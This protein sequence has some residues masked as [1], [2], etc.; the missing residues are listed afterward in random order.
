[1]LAPAATDPA[2][3]ERLSVAVRKAL[4]TSVTREALVTNGADPVGSTPVQFQSSIA[5]E[6]QTWGAI[7]AKAGVTPS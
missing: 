3:V 1:M 4:Q 6:M 5:R 7:I 2:V